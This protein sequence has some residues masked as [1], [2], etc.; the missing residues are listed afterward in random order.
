MNGPRKRHGRE[1]A[2]ARLG[3]EGRVALSKGDL[4]S[5]EKSLLEM[6]RLGSKDAAVYN[7]LAAIHD[8]RGG[9]LAEEAE[10]L[11]RA[12]ELCPENADYRMNLLKVLKRQRIAL[13]RDHRFEAAVPIARQMVEL[14]PEV[15][16]NHRELGHCCAKCGKLEDAVKHFTRAINLDPRNACYYNDL[17]LAF[18]ELRCLAEAQGAFQEVLRLEPNSPVAFSHLG[19]L[20]NLTGLSG[21]A[22]SLLER[23]VKADPACAAAQTNLGLFLRDQGDLKGCRRHYEEALKLEP[24]S[25]SALS[26]YLLSLIGDPEAE[27]GWVGREHRRFDAIVR[28]NVRRVTSPNP[29]PTRRLKIGYL[30][31]DFRTH[32]VAYF[33][34]PLL[35]HRNRQETEVACY[36]TGVTDDAMTARVRASSDRFRT[37]YRMGDDA[38]AALIQE[39]GIDILVELSGHTSENRL[40]MLANR[41]APV[42]VTY[43]G[44]ANTTGLSEM[45]YRITDEVADPVGEADTW[46]SEKLV[47]IPG[48]FLAYQAGYRPS[49]LAVVPLPAEQAGHITFGSFNNLA[50]T[51]DLVLDA[52]AAILAEIPDSE[53]LLKARG[54]RSDKVQSR[55]IEALARRGVDGSRVRLLLQEWSPKAHLA[56]YN[57]MDIA[58][59]TF[60]YNGTTTTCEALWM[61]TPVVTF[62]GNSHAGRVGASILRRTGLGE[63]VAEDREAYIRTAVE[64]ARDAARLRQLRSGLRERFLGSPVMDASRLARELEGAYREIW[65]NYCGAAAGVAALG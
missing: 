16:E 32:S 63:L 59:D 52:W 21:V 34:L 24:S 58:L 43:L 46:Y 65:R 12:V 30:S 56:L 44:Y 25:L 28:R 38:L 27:P 62:A 5:A 15:A 20:A 36:M 3:Q 4:G 11:A 35:E 37:V 53:L 33:I 1:N 13:V 54:L 48:G 2:L 45:D 7:N 64:L 9:D 19:L 55:V 51:N 60:P 42:Q 39:D 18:Y 47:R 61:G 29:D 31:P 23:A 57:Q 14:A 6:V 17:G 41:V 40:P 50:K 10:L 26:G 49:D 22:V 8:R